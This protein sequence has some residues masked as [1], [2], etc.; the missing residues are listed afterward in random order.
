MVVPS[1]TFEGEDSHRFVARL[2]LPSRLPYL[3]ATAGTPVI[4]VGHPDTAAR[5]SRS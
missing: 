5:A 1:G 4:I 3:A 2:S